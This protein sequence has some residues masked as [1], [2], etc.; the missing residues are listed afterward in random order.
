MSDGKTPTSYT[1][2][3]I[4]YLHITWLLS[5]HKKQAISSFYFLTLYPPPI[6]FQLGLNFNLV[7][8][9]PV[10]TVCRSDQFGC[11]DGFCIFAHQV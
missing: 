11:N 4:H 9:S 10:T 8:F 3:V 2:L 5:S 6:L 1:P 7:F